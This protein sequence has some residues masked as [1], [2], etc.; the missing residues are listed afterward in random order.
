MILQNSYF[1]KIFTG[2]AIANRDRIL[3]P[4][5]PFNVDWKK[6]IFKQTENCRAENHNSSQHWM[7]CGG[8]QKLILIRF[9][10]LLNHL[11][12]CFIS[13]FKNFFNQIIFWFVFQSFWNY[14]HFLFLFNFCSNLSFIGSF[15][16]L[17][18]KRKGARRARAVLVSQNSKNLYNFYRNL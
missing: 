4:R 3:R 10:F 7:G 1:F 5:T 12:F 2:F 6:V 8:M 13:F 16:T 14:L 17:R 18:H 11:H 15:F 9:K